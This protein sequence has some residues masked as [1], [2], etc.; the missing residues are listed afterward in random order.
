MKKVFPLR[1]APSRFLSDLDMCMIAVIALR[2]ETFTEVISAGARVSVFAPF[3]ITFVFGSVFCTGFYLLW[4]F[5]QSE[6]ASCA[7][8]ASNRLDLISR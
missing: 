8:Y 4:R 1:F 7:S 5:L 2:A 6:D 3:G